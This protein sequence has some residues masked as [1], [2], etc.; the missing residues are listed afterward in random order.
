MQGVFTLTKYDAQGLSDQA[1]DE[2][3][4][5]GK[6]KELLSTLKVHQECKAVSNRIFDN[7]AA[8]LFFHKFSGPDIG[9]PF[10]QQAFGASVV[11]SL[12]T[13]C[14]LTTDSGTFNYEEFVDEPGSVNNHQNL[15]DAVN[16][17]DAA[18]RFVEDSSVVYD[19]ATHVVTDPGSL[20][21]EAISFESN[22]IY[23]T[24]EVVSTNIRSLGIY[25]SEWA[26][27]LGGPERSRIGRVRLKDANGNPIILHKTNLE[28]LLVKYTFTL[29][30]N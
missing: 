23:A 15:V 5:K 19:R 28:V 27:S 21:R 7:M 1:F 6:L 26:D 2:A 25:F 18:K 4:K 13:I 29:V 16:L 17:V 20:S 12:G 9:V 11:A 8:Y 3:S 30:S 24:G 22:W 14:L 10:N